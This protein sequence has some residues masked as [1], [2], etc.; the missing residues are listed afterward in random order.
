MDK[1]RKNNILTLG[2]ALLTVIAGEEVEDEV[3]WEGEASDDAEPIE[4]DRGEDGETIYEDYTSHD[5]LFDDLS[6]HSNDNLIID[7]SYFYEDE[8]FEENESTNNEGENGVLNT[9]NEQYNPTFQKNKEQIKRDK[10]YY[11]KKVQK[12]AKDIDY[13]SK[14]VVDQNIT[15]TARKDSAY[16]LKIKTKSLADNVKKV[17]KREKE[18]KK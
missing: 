1:E 11:Q 18:L 3:E 14:K 12:D 8:N 7:D 2:C 10:E 9:P 16:T 4:D 13:H 6:S 17:E 5:I 15:K